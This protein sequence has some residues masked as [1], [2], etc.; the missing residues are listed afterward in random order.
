MNALHS[1]KNNFMQAENIEKIKSALKGLQ[2]ELT[3]LNVI[4]VSF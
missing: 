1:A 4:F 3:H 2:R